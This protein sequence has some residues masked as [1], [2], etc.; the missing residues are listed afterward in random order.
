MKKIY[1]DFDG[2][3]L[4]TQF[5]IEKIKGEQYGNLSWKDFS[6]NFEWEEFYDN[7][8]VIN[9]SINILKNFNNNDNIYIITKVDSIEEQEAKLKFIRKNNIKIP[10]YFVPYGMNKSDVVIPLSNTYLIDDNINNINDWI[11]KGGKGYH[12]NCDMNLNDIVVSL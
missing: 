6:I 2:V 5:L 3:I 12:Y 8:M 7:A 10:V 1:I 9:D 11:N 4:D